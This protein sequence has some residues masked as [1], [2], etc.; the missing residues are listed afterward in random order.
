MADLFEVKQDE[1]L[2]TK[3]VITVDP[4]KDILDSDEDGT[5]NDL[6]EVSEE[7]VMGDELY[8][9]TPLEGAGTE[10]LK[11]ARRIRLVRPIRQSPPPPQIS[12]LR[13]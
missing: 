12:G 1:I 3:D 7:D 8:G 9:Q 11:K 10:R 4:E 5:L 6:T 13:E 2:D